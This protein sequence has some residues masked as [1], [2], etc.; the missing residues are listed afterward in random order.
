[1]LLARMEPAT[2]VL[3]N[4]NENFDEINMHAFNCIGQKTWIK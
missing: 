2:P 4:K 1:M 3:N